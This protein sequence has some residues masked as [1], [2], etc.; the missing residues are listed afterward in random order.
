M[1][2]LSILPTGAICFTGE[3]FILNNL[4]PKRK[5]QGLTWEQ[6]NLL[7]YNGFNLD[8]KFI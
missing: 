8:E 5:K 4:N 3:N 7:S 2:D 1:Q 6:I